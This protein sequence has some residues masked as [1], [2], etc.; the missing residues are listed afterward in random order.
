MKKRNTRRADVILIASL[1]AVAA[2]ALVL[3]SVLRAEGDT[4]I[5]EQNGNIVAKYSLSDDGEYSL[6]GGTNTLTIKDGRA[7]MTYANCP[8]RTCVKSK[9]IHLVGESITCLPNRIS[10]YI[11]GNA[12]DGVEL[13]S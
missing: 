7:Y 3:V 11:D 4:V 1:L 6:N 5:V 8:D 2:I 13:I 10:V 12:K 9:S